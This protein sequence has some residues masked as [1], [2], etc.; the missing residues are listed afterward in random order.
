MYALIG[1]QAG[2][3]WLRGLNQNAVSYTCEP[4]GTLGANSTSKLVRVVEP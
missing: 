2:P 4:A 1:V 3:L